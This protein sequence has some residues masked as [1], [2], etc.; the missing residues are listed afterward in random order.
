MTWHP[1]YLPSTPDFVRKRFEA[2]FDQL[3]HS[4]KGYSQFLCG[5]EEGGLSIGY[6]TTEELNGYSEAKR[7]RMSRWVAYY[8][9]E[10]QSVMLTE[11]SKPKDFTLGVLMHELVHGAMD[12]LDR[13][14]S[15]VFIEL[16]S[17]A[18][19]HG[20]LFARAFDVKHGNYFSEKV[21]EK[22]A[23]LS[24][25]DATKQMLRWAFARKQLFDDELSANAMAIG[26]SLSRNKFL[27]ETNKNPRYL[28]LA[29]HWH[30]TDGNSKVFGYPEE[31]LISYRCN[32]DEFTV[33]K[34]VRAACGRVCDQTNRPERMNRLQR[35]FGC[36]VGNDCGNILPDGGRATFYDNGTL[37]NLVG[38]HGHEI[39]RFS[40]EGRIQ[41]KPTGFLHEDR[42]TVEH[43]FDIAPFPMPGFPYWMLSEVEPIDLARMAAMPFKSKNAD[44]FYRHFDKV[45]ALLP[46]PAPKLTA[47]APVPGMRMH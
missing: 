14:E 47:E 45:F 7:N 32:K 11:W 43:L 16:L 12:I 22:Y 3:P 24:G 31:E 40:P 13:R 17:E 2:V 29:A 1:R 33:L 20:K 5:D 44:E 46:A 9:C 28:I 23:L 10:K 41:G 27:G 30:I 39:V 36:D 38:S 26:R 34:L 6:T 42:R 21:R 15:R 8:D 35:D 19:E 25:E 37:R 18:K 4:I